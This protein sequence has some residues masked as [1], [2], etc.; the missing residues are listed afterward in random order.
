MVAGDG[1]LSPP[2]PMPKKPP[3]THV[4]PGFRLL[5]L[6]PQVDGRGAARVD[7]SRGAAAPSFRPPSARDFGVLDTLV[8]LYHGAALD[9]HEPA[10]LR[11]YFAARA[12]LPRSALRHGEGLC[13]VRATVPGRR[14]MVTRPVVPHSRVAPP[15]CSKQASPIRSELRCRMVAFLAGAALEVVRA[16]SQSRRAAV[17][18]RAEDNIARNPRMP[19]SRQAALR[20][21]AEAEGEAILSEVIAFREGV[22]VASAA[23]RLPP[24]AAR[25]DVLQ[26][27]VAEAAAT[28]EAGAAKGTAGQAALE[29]WAAARAALPAGPVA[30]AYFNARLEPGGRPLP[31]ATKCEVDGLLVVE[32]EPSA[33]DA[34]A[35]AASEDVGCRFFAFSPETAKHDY[36][37]VEDRPGHVPGV[38]R[39]TP[40]GG[41]LRSGGAALDG[42]RGPAL[43]GTARGGWEDVGALDGL[44][45]AGRGRQRLPGTRR[46]PRAAFTG[47]RRPAGP[48]RPGRLP[49]ACGR[50]GAA[51]RGRLR[52][53]RPGA[54]GGGKSLLL[55]GG[56]H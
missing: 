48:T 1:Q 30:R 54:G 34:A 38:N 35:T 24:W 20:A 23:L 40:V 29:R 26:A 25:D 18:A 3:P 19:G 10:R 49:R 9:L 53:G 15:P 28:S 56:R 13:A 50:C 37:A 31:R 51:A 8:S 16:V 47:G 52:Q 6:G 33:T 17:R 2:V 39:P 5:E 45:S 32:Q 27:A 11:R 22:G 7:G 21:E 46:L 55:E 44:G 14:L 4:V 43:R 42:R 36:V 12:Q 41:A